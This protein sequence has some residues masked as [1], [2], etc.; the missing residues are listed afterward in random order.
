M[1]V[2]ASVWVAACLPADAHHRQVLDF[3]G[4]IVERGETVIVPNPA[5]AEIGGAL[6]RH[7]DAPELAAQALDLLRRQAKPSIAPLD[8]ALGE[9]A[10]E[11]ARGERLRGADAV[12]VALAARLETPLVTLNQEMVERGAAAARVLRPQAA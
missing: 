7:C 4:R 11:L 6:A 9:A 3:L 10:A 2:D 5:L 1:V 8:D 12:Y